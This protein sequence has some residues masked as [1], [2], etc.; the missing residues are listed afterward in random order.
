MDIS[1]LF[2]G[3]ILAMGMLHLVN[4]VVY[5]CCPNLECADMQKNI[6][7]HTEREAHE[8]SS[9]QHDDWFVF[10]HC[11]SFVFAEKHDDVRSQ[12]QSKKFLGQP[13]TRSSKPL[14]RQR[15]A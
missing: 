8:R 3:F 10:F 14:I 4:R 7:R 12:K 5:S 6:L 2:T 11:S 13:V 15:A 1:Q 9:S